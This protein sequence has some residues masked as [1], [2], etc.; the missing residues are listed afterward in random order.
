MFNIKLKDLPAGI[1]GFIKENVEDGTYTI[2][3]NASY[4]Y[5]SLNDTCCHEINHIVHGDLHKNTGID[6]IEYLRHLG[7]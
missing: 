4:N 1:K 5:E 3:L 7:K 2:I 6:Y